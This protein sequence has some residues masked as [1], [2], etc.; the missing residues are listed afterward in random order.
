MASF[1]EV[2]HLNHWC[3]LLRIIAIIS[4]IRTVHSFNR[5]PIC[6]HLLKV[7]Y[8]GRSSAHITAEC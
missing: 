7:S 5:L 1:E 4:L 8:S 2:L 6:P 3:F